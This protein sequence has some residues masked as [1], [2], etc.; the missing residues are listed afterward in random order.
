M[1]PVT[2]EPLD[3]AHFELAAR[4]LSDSSINRW[5]T[6]E[7]RHR[8]VTGTVLAMAVR[9]RRNR[10]FLVR[11]DGQ[12]CGI[13]ALAEIDA[14]DRTAMVWYFLGEQ[15]LSRR[16]ITSS[17]VCQL[18]EVAFNEVGLASLYAWTMDDNV[19]SQKTLLNAG[20][21]EAGRLR[22]SALSGSRQVDRIYFDILPD[23]LQTP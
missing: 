14:A 5:L 13:V 11:H 17:A 19:A 20:F 6:P 7:W 21:R 23:E 9:N 12:P 3:P 2:I 22:Q 18:A 8:D 16:N 10:L 1:R 4:W 15:D